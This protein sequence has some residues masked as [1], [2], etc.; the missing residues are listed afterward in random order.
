VTRPLVADIKPL[1][2]QDVD[3]IAAT[4]AEQNPA[5]AGRFL[6]DFDAAVDR[7]LEFPELAQLWRTNRP[8]QLATVRRYVM[9]RFRA[10]IFYRPTATTLEVLRVLHHSQDAPSILED[11]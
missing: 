1:A 5:A 7:L 3:M 10:T 8:D 2:Q 4:I 6:D 9:R 11:L